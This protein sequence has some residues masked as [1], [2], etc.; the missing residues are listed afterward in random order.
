MDPAAAIRTEF[1]RRWWRQCAATLLFLLVV[2]AAGSSGPREQDSVLGLGPGA[3]HKVLIAG[4][5]I[6]IGIRLVNWRCPACDT[7]FWRQIYPRH[8][9][10]CGVELREGAG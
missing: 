2:F 7:L 6:V 4:A 10:D 8:C 1:R 3:W 5:V 9:P